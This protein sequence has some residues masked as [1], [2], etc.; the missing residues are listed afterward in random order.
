MFVARLPGRAWGRRGRD[1][2]LVCLPERSP[3]REHLPAHG[4]R[5]RPPPGKKGHARPARNT[6]RPGKPP[7]VFGDLSISSSP[8][9]HPSE[10]R[11]GWAQLPR[12]AL[13]TGRG[14]PGVSHPL[15]TPGRP[16]A[17]G[18]TR[19]HLAPRGR[20]SVHSAQP[21]STRALAFLPRR[22]LFPTARSSS[23]RSRGGLRR[24]PGPTSNFASP[25]HQPEAPCHPAAGRRAGEGGGRRRRGAGREGW[26]EPGA[27]LSPRLIIPASENFPGLRAVAVHWSLMLGGGGVR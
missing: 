21:Q 18:H 6:A 26:E 4:P 11:T 14:E 22:P 23:P 12:K 17:P 25:P 9:R 24:R 5:R 20:P 13:G 19:V 3:E 10:R 16:A 1:S 7:S 15:P 27:G 2:W 8:P